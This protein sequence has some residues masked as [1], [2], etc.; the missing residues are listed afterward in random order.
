MPP[1]LSATNQGLNMALKLRSIAM[2]DIEPACQVGL[3]AWINGI[4]PIVKD[5]KAE[6]FLRV[7]VLF[8]TFLMAH[9]NGGQGATDQLFLAD[10]GGQIIGFYNLDCKSADLTD[11]WV[12]PQW[13]GQGIA[14]GLMR[15]AK[16]RAEAMGL[17]RL[18]LEVLEGNERAIAFY[19]KM[20]FE[21]VDRIK[22]FDP[23]LRRDL[24]KR[25]MSCRLQSQSE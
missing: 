21:E 7:E 15:H 3:S 14:S 8:R 17:T 18:G 24:A 20:G 4:A 9:C 12:G 10:L 25:I 16:D 11:L 5:L 19:Q 13:H 22:K 6:E 23:F 2:Q 1:F